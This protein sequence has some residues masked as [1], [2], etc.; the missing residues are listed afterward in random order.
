MVPSFFINDG[1]AIVFFDNDV[2]FVI[3]LKASDIINN[4]GAVD[5]PRENAF[6]DCVLQPVVNGVT[7]KVAELFAKLRQRFEVLG[8]IRST[9]T[10]F[11][12]DGYASLMMST[13]ISFK[14]GT[15]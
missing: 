2:F 1:F 3:S 13:L 10:S 7:S 6:V 15:R 4:A 14:S 8:E 12:T 11:A 5:T 9:L